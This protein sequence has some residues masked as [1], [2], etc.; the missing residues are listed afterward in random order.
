M[1]RF[2]TASETRIGSTRL[3]RVRAMRGFSGFSSSG[4]SILG[5]GRML[6]IRTVS[7][8]GIALVA[9]FAL[10]YTGIS[11]NMP[12][13]VIAGWVFLAVAIFLQLAYLLLRN[14]RPG[15]RSEQRAGSLRRA[16]FQ[17]LVADLP[18]SAEFAEVP[19][20]P[21]FDSD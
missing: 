7:P 6:D 17:L 5:V 3:K 13:M 19:G 18:E 10:I 21:L 4:E 20:V 11:M 16:L 15:V 2:E 12:E 8:P 14:W 9:A 1:P